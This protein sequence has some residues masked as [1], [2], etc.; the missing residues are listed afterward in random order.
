MLFHKFINGTK[1]IIYFNN[2]FLTMSN[3]K[4]PF[5]KVCFDAGKPESEY[6]NHFVK[7]VPGPN[8]KVICPTLLG[9]SCRYCLKNGHMVSHCPDLTENKKKGKKISVTSASASV[10]KACKKTNMFHHL[11]FDS[12]Y[13]SEEDVTIVNCCEPIVEKHHVDAVTYASILAKPKVETSANACTRSELTF[14]AC[15]KV[16]KQQP[17]KYSFKK[18]WA[19]YDSSSDEEE[20]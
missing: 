19:A 17:Y 7:N 15:A 18:S 5:C 6:T 13:D 9:L 16:Q 2:N 12:D 10:A 14:D 3:S 8:G 1:I 11:T 4:K 20:D